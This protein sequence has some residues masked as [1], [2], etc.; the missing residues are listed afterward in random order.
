MLGKIGALYSAGAD[1]MACFPWCKWI[2]PATRKARNVA[3][4]VSAVCKTVT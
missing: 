4:R 1:V 2:R 3:F